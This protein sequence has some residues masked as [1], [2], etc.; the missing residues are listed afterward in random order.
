MLN[1]PARQAPLFG[2]NM[3]GIQDTHPLEC[4]SCH[5]LVMVEVPKEGGTTYTCPYCTAVV[6]VI[7]ELKEKKSANT[8]SG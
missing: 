4:P 6:N 8:G 7:S 5:A 2:G 3:P 1:P